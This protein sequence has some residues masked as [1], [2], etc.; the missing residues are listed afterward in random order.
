MGA[1]SHNGLQWL[2]AV[3]FPGRCREAPCRAS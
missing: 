3:H 2:A 1:A